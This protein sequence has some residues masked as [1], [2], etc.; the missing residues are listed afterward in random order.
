STT[1]RIPEEWLSELD[2]TL[3]NGDKLTVNGAEMPIS[4]PVPYQAAI[5]AEV[6]RSVSYS[7]VH[8][9]KRI[10]LSSAAPT[11]GQ[12]LWEAGY[13]LS[14]SDLIEPAPETPLT[15]DL[16]IRLIP[17]KQIQV[18]ADGKT[19]N[20]TTSANTVGS[21]LSQ[22]GL[23]L[24]GL[25][26]S[27][28]AVEAPIPADGRIKVVRVKEE[29][30]INQQPLAFTTTYQ[31]V[32]D[33]EID[34]FN[35]IQTGQTGVQAQR[36]R[37]RYEDGE[38]ASREVE[39][40]WTLIDP[41][42][43]IEGYGTQIIVRTEMTPDGPIEYWRKL[44]MYATSYSPC[45]LGV[46]WCGYTTAS[47]ETMRKGLAAVK[48]DWYRVMVGQYVYVPDYGQAMIADVGR[49]VEDYW[50]DLAYTDEEYIGWHFWVPVYFL[51][52]VPPEENILYI[53]P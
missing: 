1:S 52:P 3:V 2:I 27:I 15:E 33:L 46:S 23:T 26:Y 25:D 41:V 5:S 51:T 24:Q 35:V 42:P 30:L 49:P 4:R 13:I 9:G 21:A 39:D 31:P 29:V 22:V 48:I 44:D 12:A 34:N 18:E 11:V 50:I 36:V 17:G 7:L 8:S 45:N 14:E 32:P 28:P 43:R 38:E 47:G 10:S 16:S 19:L 20:L 40:Q 37:I 6:L 53:L